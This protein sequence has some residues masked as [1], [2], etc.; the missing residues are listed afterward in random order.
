MNNPTKTLAFAVL[1]MLMGA[2][3]IP[4]FTQAQTATG[5]DAKGPYG[6]PSNPFFEGETVSFSADVLNGIPEDYYFRWDVNNDGIW[7]KD[8]FNLIK[9]NPY[10]DHTYTDDYV[11]EAKV[12][13]WDG[14]SYRTQRD[15]GKILNGTSPTQDIPTGPNDFETVGVKFSVIDNVTIHQLGIYNDPDDPYIFVLNL[16]LWT[17]SGTLMV[18]I[19]NPNAPSGGWSWF[20]H[21]PIDLFAGQNYIVSA[22]IRGSIVPAMNN[23]GPTPDGRIDPT[24]FMILSGSPFGFPATSLGSSPLPLVDINYSYDYPV[25]DIFQDFADVQVSNLPP[26][27][28]AGDD[29]ITYSGEVTNFTGYFEDA[30]VDDT[31]TIEWDFDDGNITTGTLGP[32]HIFLLA[33]VYNV[34]LTVTD[35]DGG[36]GQDIVTVIVFRFRPVEELIG[37]LIGSVGGMGLHDGIENSMISM[38]HNALNSNEKGNEIATINKIMAFIN[39]VYAQMGKKIPE[40]EALAL[41]ELA[42]AIIQQIMESM[43]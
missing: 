6:T 33:G 27:V 39:H 20:S 35:D 37:N 4:L 28:W 24:D 8:D 9:G 29:I 2:S 19:S 16:R 23:P 42:H 21:S 1:I 34:T 7:E 40:E 18:S 36:F 11:G 41:I 43:K 32:L 31:H 14:V 5:V 38:L 25:P 12:E 30:G 17:E 15:F 10:Y 22:G 26:V 13:A 3:L